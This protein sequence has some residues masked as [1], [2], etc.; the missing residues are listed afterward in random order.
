M[1]ERLSSNEGCKFV[2]FIINPVVLL[3]VPR[4]YRMKGDSTGLLSPWAPSAS[5]MD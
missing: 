5:G 1:A 3:R 4:Y 2:A